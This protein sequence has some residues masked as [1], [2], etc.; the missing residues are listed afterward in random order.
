[1]RKNGEW[2]I[3]TTDRANTSTNNINNVNLVKITAENLQDV[4]RL[5]VAEEQKNYV[6]IN[7]VS[8][9]EGCFYDGSWFRA[10][11]HN[12]I[13]VGF[14]ML[15]IDDEDGQTSIWKFMIDKNHQ[16]K[17][18]GKKA[19]DILV[20]N[21]KKDIRTKEIFT[22]CGEGDHSPK[23]FYLNYGFE[24]TN[25]TRHGEELLVFKFK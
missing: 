6:D 1:M 19:L 13:P 14:V 25:E 23:G 5:K 7:S 3:K 15:Y 22:T 4:M 9:A 17:G 2:L 11:Y 10:I 24:T 8:I 12:E 18:L 21:T 20:E 16:D